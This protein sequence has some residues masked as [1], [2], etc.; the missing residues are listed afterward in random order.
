M[1]DKNSTNSGVWYKTCFVF[2][3][4]TILSFTQHLMSK[5]C[6]SSTSSFVTIAGP[7]GANVS[8]V[9]PLKTCLS[10]FVKSLALTSFSIVY[11]AT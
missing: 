10:I 11:P 7:I 9:L 2:S 8:N 3:S 5:L 1:P 4:W 6:G